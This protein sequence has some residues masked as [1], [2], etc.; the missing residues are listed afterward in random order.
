MLRTSISSGAPHLTY[1]HHAELHLLLH[2]DVLVVLRQ[3][4]GAVDLAEVHP[5]VIEGD[6]MNVNGS[7]LN[8]AVLRPVPLQAAAEIFMEDVATGVVIVENLRARRTK[9]KRIGW[10]EIFF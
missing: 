4:D 10:I 5:R 7:R 8:V 2:S 6:V 9:R 1:S 3:E